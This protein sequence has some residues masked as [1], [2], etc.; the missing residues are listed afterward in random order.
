MFLQ[1]SAYHDTRAL[2][3]SLG[4]KTVYPVTLP[5]APGALEHKGDYAPFIVNCMALV[6]SFP[7]PD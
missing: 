7:F 2:I 5:K 3:E 1:D 4:A 6:S